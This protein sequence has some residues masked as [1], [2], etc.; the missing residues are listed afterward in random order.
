VASRLIGMKAKKEKA[1][2]EGKRGCYRSG[3]KDGDDF[4]K[5]NELSANS[6]VNT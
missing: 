4:L 6:F 3:S 1:R 5:I 2:H